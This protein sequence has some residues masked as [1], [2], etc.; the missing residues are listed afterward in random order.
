MDIIESNPQNRYN[1]RPVGACLNNFT[2]ERCNKI[3]GTR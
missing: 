1:G 3:V 2:P